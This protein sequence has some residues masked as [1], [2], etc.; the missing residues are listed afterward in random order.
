VSCDINDPPDGN[1]EAVLDFRELFF[2][3]VMR[4]C[5]VGIFNARV[6]LSNNS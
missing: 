3:G 4:P 6:S 2:S 1:G 5:P